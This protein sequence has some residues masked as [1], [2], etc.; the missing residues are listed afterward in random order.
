VR[1][2][3]EYQLENCGVSDT[4][5]FRL[6]RIVRDEWTAWYTLWRNLGATENQIQCF[7]LLVAE[8]R[9]HEEAEEIEVW[10]PSYPRSLQTV[11]IGNNEQSVG[12]IQIHYSKPIAE[13]LSSTH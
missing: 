5:P 7:I 3:K 11:C 8:A 6:S 10:A 2:I 12:Q 9:I 4:P 1:T 13:I